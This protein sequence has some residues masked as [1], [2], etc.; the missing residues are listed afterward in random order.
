MFK[1][2]EQLRPGDYERHEPK[3]LRN[4]AAT[5]EEVPIGGR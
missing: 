2:P 5:S 1:L 4:L 3:N